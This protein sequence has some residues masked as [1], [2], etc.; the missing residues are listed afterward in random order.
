MPLK[1]ENFLCKSFYP[2][3]TMATGRIFKHAEFVKTLNKNSIEAASESEIQFLTEL[4]YNIVKNKRFL[5]SIEDKV[6][7]EKQKELL[8]VISKTRQFHQAQLLFNSLKPRTIAALKRS[9]AH[10]T[11]F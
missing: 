5:I 2:N 11:N 7:L 10:N 8:L 3:C 9:V 6:I 1:P 4:V